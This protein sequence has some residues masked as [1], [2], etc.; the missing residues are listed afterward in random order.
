MGNKNNRKEDKREGQVH[1][2]EP[3]LIGTNSDEIIRNR[4]THDEAYAR[5]VEFVLGH[6]PMC[7]A[8]LT[9]RIHS[10]D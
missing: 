7:A 8:K 4:S 1:T 9:V 2:G 3:E 6:L 10:W 5:G